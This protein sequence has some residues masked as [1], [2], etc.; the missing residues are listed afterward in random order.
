MSRSGYTDDDDSGTLGLYRAAVNRAICGKRGQGLLRD[1]AVAL[2]AMPEKALAADSLVTADGEFCTLGVLGA[3]RGID[4]A[5]LD[6]DDPEQVAKAFGIAESMARE[7]VWENDEQD[8]DYEWVE[9][10]LCGPLPRWQ[11]EWHHRVRQVLMAV[12]DGPQR[13]WTRMRAWVAKNIVQAPEAQ[14]KEKA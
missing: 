8:D 12:S 6:P 4:I 7:I 3:A 1:L 14:S 11:G 10:E 5:K 2:D 9:I 13:R